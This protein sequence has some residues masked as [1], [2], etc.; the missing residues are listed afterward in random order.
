MKITNINNKTPFYGAVVY[1]NKGEFAKQI[2]ECSYGCA[3]QADGFVRAFNALKSKVE[4]NTPDS[5]VCTIGMPY[6]SCYNFLTEAG[7]LD[8][9]K[10]DEC[11][12]NIS[13]DKEILLKKKTSY[14]CELISSTLE[15][16]AKRIISY[17]NFDGNRK[18]GAE[19]MDASSY[20]HLGEENSEQET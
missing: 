9:E 11:D 7:C 14:C 17:A 19:I 10:K 3:K 15:D 20:R 16:L 4:E 13:I 18:D 1:K 2:E 6:E 8:S 12:F 5:F